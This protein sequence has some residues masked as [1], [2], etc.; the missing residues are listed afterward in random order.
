MTYVTHYKL[1][2]SGGVVW[3]LEIEILIGAWEVL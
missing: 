2:G 3:M 1:R